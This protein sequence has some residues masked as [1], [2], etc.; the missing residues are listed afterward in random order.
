[1]N[2]RDVWKLRHQSNCV[3]KSSVCATTRRPASSPL[4]LQTDSFTALR[5]T[6]NKHTRP[7][8]SPRAKYNWGTATSHDIGWHYYDDQARKPMNQVQES[9]RTK[10]IVDMQ[11]TRSEKL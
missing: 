4:A 10:W 2:M 1:M 7:L 5:T 3:T 6:R 8:E 11:K 9:S